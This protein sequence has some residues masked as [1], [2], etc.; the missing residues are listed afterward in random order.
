MSAVELDG[1]TLSLLS[2][3]EL[4]NVFSDFICSIVSDPFGQLIW[5]VLSFKGEI[6]FYLQEVCC[7][8]SF[9]LQLSF[10]LL[11]KCHCPW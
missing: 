8:D 10:V 4:S 3:F 5:P 11:L 6:L 9:L 2:Y 1:S 7:V